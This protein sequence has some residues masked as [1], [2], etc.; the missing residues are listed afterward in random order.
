MRRS[1]KW[2]TL[3]LVVC[4]MLGMTACG[5]PSI[6]GTWKATLQVGNIFT[7]AVTKALAEEDTAQIMEYLEFDELELTII[8]KYDKEGNCSIQ[9]EK[10]SAEEFA[11]E[12][13][14]ALTNAMK[15][16]FAE[17]FKTV[18]FSIEQYESAT[19]KEFDDFLEESIDV[20][21]VV[22][23]VLKEYKLNYELDNH[24][25]YT[26]NSSENKDEG[27][28]TVVQVGPEKMVWV[29]M[30]DLGDSESELSGLFNALFPIEFIRQ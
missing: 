21:Q 24:N 18:G 7:D 17:Y 19:G 30:R 25:L 23:G 9:F 1:M 28:C 11:T 4:M 14:E 13:K 12:F 29:S 15:L 16:H 5:K 26:Y 8:A 2:V 10:E 27:E 22:Q 20:D 6:V 3:L